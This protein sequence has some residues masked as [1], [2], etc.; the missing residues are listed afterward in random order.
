ML[1]Q[2]PFRILGFHSDNE[3]NARTIFKFRHTAGFNSPERR[4]LAA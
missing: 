4:A 1:E 3:L 2:F